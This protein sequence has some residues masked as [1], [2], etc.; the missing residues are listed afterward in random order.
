MNIPTLDEIVVQSLEFF[1]K[2]PPPDFDLAKYNLPF[3]VGSG[4]AISTGRIIFS[5]QAAI[6]A[7][8]SN[9]RSLVES[10]KP[11]IEKGLITQVVV[12]SASG[13]KDS[14]WEVELSKE[15][16]LKTTLLTCKPQSSAAAIADEVIACRSIDEPYTYNTSTYIGMILAA[17][18]EDP[19]VIA[20]LIDQLSLPEGF[21]D[22]EAYSFVLPDQYINIAPMLKVKGDELFGPHLMLR[23]NS[24]GNARHAKYVHPW[25]K[26]LVIT[27]GDENT[28][29]GHPDH[30][31]DVPLPASA[32]YAAVMAISYYICGQIQA[33]K[34]PYFKENVEA[35]TS[36]YG[37]KAYGTEQTFDVIVPGN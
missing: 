31:W 24:F 35:F 30:R 28:V 26:E 16:G 2:T 9:F 15:L 33:A 10:Y 21:K 11:V 23:A 7:D 12:I 3:V 13:E 34:H 25:E 8:E 5:D 18:K 37:P 27:I 1:S 14:V 32:S 22:Y 36:D 17:T 4:N 29:F 19:E 20:G 6:F